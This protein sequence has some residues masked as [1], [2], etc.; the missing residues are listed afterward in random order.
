MGRH[1]GI[2][3]PSSS[4]LTNTIPVSEQHPVCS[5][6]D[7]V[8]CVLAGRPNKADYLKATQQASKKM[9]AFEGLLHV[10]KKCL[11]QQRRGSHISV[12]TGINMGGGA[13]VSSLSIS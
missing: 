7:S 11:S 3:P 2:N 9:E 13:T 1:V 12:H 4:V 5:K 8:I 10:S 6:D